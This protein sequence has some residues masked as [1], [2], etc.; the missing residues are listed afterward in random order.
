MKKKTKT[1]FKSKNILIVLSIFCFSMISLSFFTDMSTGPLKSVSNFII[2]PIQKGINN[3]GLWLTDKSDYFQE[4]DSVIAENATLTQQMEQLTAENTALLQEQY[5]LERLR[6]FY[7]LE[8]TYT[9]SP[10]VAARII[11]KTT[12]N[13]YTVFNIDKGSNDGLAKDMNVIAI[14]NSGYGLVGIITDVGPDWAKVRAVI[15]DST[16]ISA[17]ILNT[18]DRCV[19][20]GNLLLMD[21]N[22]IEFS[23]LLDSDNN[24]AVGDKIVTSNISDK[25]LSGI[26]IGY[27][28]EI[29]LDAN[30]LTK[31]G[32]LTPAV[33][34]EHLQEVLVLT[35]LKSTGEGS[36]E[37]ARIESGENTANE[38]AVNT[39]EEETGALDTDV[40][41]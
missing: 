15:D 16:N 40:I 33:D 12:G 9:D 39:A 27:I 25:Y 38:T 28:T 13:W 31:S 19:V 37:G 36:N 8:G 10:M 21:Q 32:T 11:S 5:E 34:F 18:S 35:N 41:E 6:K 17:M 4:L 2:I 14:S 29:S 30:N 23:G 22:K 1:S 24:V 26:L 20:S 7:N 3:V